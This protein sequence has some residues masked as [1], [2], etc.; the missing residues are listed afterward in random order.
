MMEEIK[1]FLGLS[2]YLPHRIKNR[3]SLEALWYSPQEETLGEAKSRARDL[4]IVDGV[5]GSGLTSSGRE[6][7]SRRAGERVN[8]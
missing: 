5:S 6:W 8:A 3:N 4:T 7:G 2:P 1:T